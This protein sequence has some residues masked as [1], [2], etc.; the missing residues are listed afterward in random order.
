MLDTNVAS[1]PGPEVRLVAVK[2]ILSGTSARWGSGRLAKKGHSRPC[3]QRSKMGPIRRYGRL[4]FTR[5]RQTAREQNGRDEDEDFRDAHYGFC[6]RVRVRT[7]WVLRAG[8]RALGCW[9]A[10]RSCAIRS[11]GRRSS[12]E[13]EASQR[14]RT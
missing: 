1:G 12:V 9:R 10:L 4:V 11:C 5:R 3:R 6:S 14:L 8:R 13:V 7:A 2:Q